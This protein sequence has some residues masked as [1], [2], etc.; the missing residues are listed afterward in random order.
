[1]TQ[2]TIKGGCHCGKVRIEVDVDLQAGTNRCNCSICSR[3]RNW[4]VIVKPEAL[5]LLAGEQELSTYEWGPK[6][7]KR[8]FCSHCGVHVFS[9]GFLEQIGGHYRSVNIAALDLEP[10]VLDQLP[11]RYY[12][13]R[14]N[15]WLE[16]PKHTHYL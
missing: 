14:N 6:I 1:M 12:D 5:R 11:I 7:S 9:V 10:E 13:G 8:R 4:S 3:L 16:T 15:A 2:Q